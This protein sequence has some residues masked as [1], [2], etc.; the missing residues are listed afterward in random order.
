[1][2]RRPAALLLTL[3]LGSVLVACG[4]DSSEEGSSGGGGAS[5]ESVSIEGEV[6]EA[7]EV[8]WDGEMSADEVESKVVAEGDG[9]EIGEGDQVFA[10][11]WLGNGT[12]QEQAY[13]TYD[14]DQ[15]QL[16]TVGKDTLSELFLE[17]LQGQTVG[18]RVAVAASA[19][20]AF[21]EAGNPQIG[22]G[23][24]DTVL[25]VI[26]LLGT[27]EDGPQGTDEKAP[28]WVP[29][30]V[31]GDEAPTG[32]DFAGTP[33]P[34][35]KLQ[36]AVLVKGDGAAVEKGQTIAV[37]YLGQVYGGKKPFDESYSSQSTSFPIGVGQ[38]VKGWDQALVGQTVG[39]R[40]VLAIP[41]ALG[42]GKGGNEQ[43]GIKGDDTLYFVV[44][45]LGAA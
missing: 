20:T 3:L 24:K 14:A 35:G 41:P 11:I 17:G 42:Y 33:K 9:A 8:T 37:D 38:V 19:E 23:N 26:D 10:Q 5:L 27:V 29:S 16:L 22:I 44:D 34:T 21:G 12:T 18:S 7:P 36:T 43:A 15:P 13:S 30:L 6:G 40:V 1:M 39:S 28:S 32:L 4:D 31:G 2:I 45:I 25:T